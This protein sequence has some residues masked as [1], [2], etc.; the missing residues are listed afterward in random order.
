MDRA[1]L[2]ALFWFV[3]RP[4]HAHF[5]GLDAALTNAQHHDCADCY[6]V[7]LNE[8]KAVFG[9]RPLALWEIARRG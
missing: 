9:L 6:S 7:Y 2:A 3:G 1:F 5:D 4:V 8:R